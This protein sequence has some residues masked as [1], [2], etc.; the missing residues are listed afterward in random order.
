MNEFVAID[1]HSIPIKT[2]D[3]ESYMLK[4]DIAQII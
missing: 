2:G 3:T 1:G 4:N